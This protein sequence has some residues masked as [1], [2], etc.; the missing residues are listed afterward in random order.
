MVGGQGI[1]V[2]SWV[3]YFWGGE[4]SPQ[5][6]PDDLYKVQ[7]VTSGLAKASFALLSSGQP[8]RSRVPIG[9]NGLLKFSTNWPKV[10][11]RLSNHTKLIDHRHSVG[12]FFVCVS[13]FLV[14]V[15]VVGCG[16]LWCGSV[17]ARLLDS[18]GARLIPLSLLGPDLPLEGGVPA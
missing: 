10:R 14:V 2:D 13:F 12:V 17:C 18:P 5:S 16:L 6:P 3:K 8:Q 4:P 1:K 11:I 15:V 9:Q 7:K